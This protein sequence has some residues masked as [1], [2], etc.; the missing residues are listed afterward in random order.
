MGQWLWPHPSSPRGI[1]RSCPGGRLFVVLQALGASAPLPRQAFSGTCSVWL[2]LNWALWP[3]GL[4]VLG[5]C[6]SLEV[7]A[8]R[9]QVSFL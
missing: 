4:P 9:F 5:S 6:F 1:L 8:H 7:P 2:N 3:T